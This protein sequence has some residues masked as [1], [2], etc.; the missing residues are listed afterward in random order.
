MTVD[1]S[2]DDRELTLA[3][4][5]AGHCA[6]HGAHKDLSAQGIARPRVVLC[7]KGWLVAKARPQGTHTVFTRCLLVIRAGNPLRDG[8]RLLLAARVDVALEAP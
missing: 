2:P 3:P 5:K 6:R 1:A 7:H 4:P 8:Q